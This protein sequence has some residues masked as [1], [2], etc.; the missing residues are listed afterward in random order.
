MN[1]HN[2]TMRR[3]PGANTEKCVVCDSPLTLFSDST[4]YLS[5]EQFSVSTCGACG[6]GRTL[7]PVP[8]EELGK[9]YAAGYYKKRKSGADEYINKS[10]VRKVSARSKGTKHLLD[11]GCGN[12]ALIEK[13]GNLGWKAEGA[14]MAPPE[15]FVSDEVQKKVFIGDVRKA[16]YA[17]H[18]FDVVTLFHVLE[19]L[20]EPRSYLEKARELLTDT[21]LLVVEVPNLDSWQARMT[22][23]EW[24]NLDVPRHVFHYTP[25]S[26]TKILE[27]SGFTVEST[28]HYSPIYSPFGFLQSLLNLVTRRNNILFDFLNGKITLS[29]YAAQHIRLSDLLLTA[30]F[31]PL[32]LIVATPLTL[33]EVIFKRGGIMV[34]Y[35]RPR[36]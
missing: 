32:A 5:G 16:T 14:E 8:A 28:A 1:L 7:P 27:Q 26:L 12:G 10:R 23:G 30:L 15:H 4:D 18:S 34:M 25:T 19:H 11:I 17:T 29:N 31:L 22:R 2:A 3:M 36:S 13:F 6:L 9:Y 20:P 33:L 35:A 21:G 24:F